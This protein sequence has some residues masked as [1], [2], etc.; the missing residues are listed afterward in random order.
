[1]KFGAV[2]RPPSIGARLRGAAPGSAGEQPG[3]EL[4]AGLGRHL[5]LAAL[6]GRVPRVLRA[7]GGDGIAAVN[8]GLAIFLAKLVLSVALLWLVLTRL[9]WLEVREALRVWDA[10]AGRPR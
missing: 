3:V 4:G 6:R 2:A 9:T 7:G 10:P 1:M 5:Q 8:R